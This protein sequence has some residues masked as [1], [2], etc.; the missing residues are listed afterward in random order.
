[1]SKTLAYTPLLA[2]LLAAAVAVSPALAGPADVLA[3]DVR[4]G[5]G[6]H[7]FAVTIRSDDTG[8]ARYCDRFEV[9][10]PDGAVIATRVLLHPHVD[11][12][13]FTR[14]L[15]G[16]KVP[17]GLD[18]VTVRARMKPGGASG[19]TITISWPPSR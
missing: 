13:P 5:P 6:G 1:M 12:Q 16:V 18:S 14:S 10:A 11:E 3:V 7:E 2:G 15:S 17:A 8:W 4:E 9:V 19:E